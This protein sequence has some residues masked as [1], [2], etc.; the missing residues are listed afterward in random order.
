MRV[1][2]DTTLNPML[3][4][5]PEPDRP[6]AQETP[7]QAHALSA[8]AGTLGTADFVNAALE[9]RL[10]RSVQADGAAPPA[11]SPD[12]VIR[13]AALKHASGAARPREAL[14]AWVDLTKARAYAD[15]PSDLLRAVSQHHRRAIAAGFEAAPDPALLEDASVLD[16][17]ALLYHELHS[18]GKQDAGTPPELSVL[19]S[20]FMKALS[21]DY[22]KRRRLEAL[23]PPPAQP[24]GSKPFFDGF[25]L[26]NAAGKTF[27]DLLASPDTFRALL[28]QALSAEQKRS[29]LEEKFAHMG[30]STQY[31]IGTTEHALAST[32]IRAQRYLGAAATPRFESPADVVQ[33]FQQLEVQYERERGRFPVSPRLQFSLLL[34]RSSGVDVVTPNELYGPYVT[35]V[36]PR[37]MEQWRSGNEAASKWLAA[38]LVPWY[39]GGVRWNERD[40][41]TR[42]QAVLS[43]MNDLHASIGKGEPVSELAAELKQRGIFREWIVGADWQTRAQALVTYSNERLLAAYGT[44]P[45]FDRA[46]A[47]A[48]I[49]LKY[50][51]DEEEMTD[52]RDYVITGDNPNLSSSEFGDRIDEFLQ[53]ADWSGL[54]GSTM[55]VAGKRINPREELQKAEEAFNSSLSSEPW[56]RAKAKEN[57]RAGSQPL[58]QHLIDEEAVRISN[59]FRT[60]TET[61]RNWMRGFQTWINMMPVAGPIYNIEEGVRHRDAMQ[62][63]FGVLFLGLDAF[64]LTGGGPGGARG[65]ANGAVHAEAGEHIA[66]SNFRHAARSVDVSPDRAAAHP[67][68]AEASI[69]PVHIGQLDADIPEAF[70]GFA[71]RV[72]EGETDLTWNGY[73]LVHVRNENRVVPVE[74]AGGSYHEIDWRTGERV[75]NAPLIQRDAQTSAFRSGGGLKGGAPGGDGPIRGTEVAGRVTVDKVTELLKVADDLRLRKFDHLFDEGFEI[76]PPEEAVST[77]DARAFYKKL[78]ETSGTFRRLMNAHADAF[79]ELRNVTVV[80]NEGEAAQEAGA[81]APPFER[82]KLTVGEEGPLGPHK[83]AYTDFDNRRIYLPSDADVAAMPYMSAGGVETVSREQ[84]YL[85]EMVHAITGARDPERAV[86][87]LNRGPVVYLTDK[88]LSEAGYSIPEQVMY[89]RQ[90]SVPDMPPHNAVEYHREAATAAAHAENRHLDRLVDQKMPKSAPDTLVEGVPVS[91]RPTV[92]GTKRILERV[93]AAESALDTEDFLKKFDETFVFAASEPSKFEAVSVMTEEVVRFYLR[94]HDK[95]PTFRVLFEEMPS[96]EGLPE[97]QFVFEK[98]TAIADLPAGMA[99]SCVNRATK[100]LYVFDDGTRYLTPDGLRDVEYERKLAHAMVCLMTGL[101]RRMPPA[102]AFTNRGADVLLTERI[103]KEAGYHLPQQLAAA[104]A[105]ASNPASEARLLS[106]QT[107]AQRS[108]AVEDRYLSL[109]S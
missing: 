31:A 5:M 72:R 51:M 25:A 4:L 81:I 98:R 78:Y 21:V 23:F 95:S 58:A 12:I 49:L 106:Y 15:S 41:T 77:M 67:V 33:R 86:D 14:L 92:E 47:A 34:A 96:I 36:V 102:E 85:H 46:Q 56:V 43:V 73:E 90:N 22:E 28:L 8:Q 3:L 17:A 37:V 32:I 54:I 82:W 45:Q 2:S 50:G 38:K 107:S 62:I 97:W 39:D 71:A 100:R 109:P 52:E 53:R 55:R 48:D 66:M 30:Q 74:R 20:T 6:T 79:D 101:G 70:Q 16:E 13:G 11:R 26:R 9:Q 88:I 103:L 10:R 61:H 94:L 7:P 27:D 60:E 35:E 69:D 75:R 63:A 80:R 42:A 89:R 1:Q 84:A 108:A 44:P 87:M 24:G 76:V 99:A 68:I 93:N 29:L 19:R 40:E 91:S 59:N 65:G 83:K 64:D 105:T 57:L 18:E 104:L